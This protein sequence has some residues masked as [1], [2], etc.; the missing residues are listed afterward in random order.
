M[1]DDTTTRENVKS[2]EAKNTQF[3]INPNEM[4]VAIIKKKQM[5]LKRN[6]DALDSD[7]KL[8]IDKETDECIRTAYQ[9]ILILPSLTKKDYE[10]KEWIWNHGNLRSSEEIKEYK[11]AIRDKEYY[12]N[13]EY[14]KDMKSGWWLPWIPMILYG[15]VVIWFFRKQ[16]IDSLVITFFSFP[17]FLFLSLICCWILPSYR[18]SLADSHR[19]PKN[20][21]R[22][23]KEVLNKKIAVAS[24]IGSTVY[25]TKKAKDCIKETA[26]PDTWK[27]IK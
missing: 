1:I 7:I 6:F 9:N 27:E 10:Y 2:A 5:E 3:E 21:P 23:Q 19:V 13:G 14:E 22:Y 11:K 20:D 8:M 26:D 12:E 24:M 17:F 16:T 15:F 18:T 25:M 4:D